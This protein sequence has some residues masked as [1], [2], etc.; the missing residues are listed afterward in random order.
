MASLNELAE[1]LAERAG[2]Q[3][4]Q[5]FNM[6]MKMLVNVWRSRLVR[7]T[8]ERNRQ[9]RIFFRQWFETPM[10]TVN[11]TEFPG[12]PDVPVMRSECQIPKSL[13]GLTAWS[14]TTLAP[15]DKLSAFQVFTEQHELLPALN[16][17]YTG[18]KIKALWLNNYIYCFNTLTL[19]AI[20]G[21]SVFDDVNALAN[22][23]CSCNTNLCFDD[24]LE[25][26]APREIQQKIIQSILSVELKIETKK[27]EDKEVQVDA[28]EKA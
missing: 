7:D 24:D 19:P 16:A 9:D 27:D 18:R 6:E 20:L 11:I 28:P 2:R 4:S 21:A 12:F 3:F 15:H 14:S 26:P 10:I 23:Q 25:Y 5:P 17:R 1:T 8:L 22:L 13:T